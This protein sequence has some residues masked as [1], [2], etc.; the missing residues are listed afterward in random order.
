MFNQGLTIWNFA[1][2]ASS[3]PSSRGQKIETASLSG[4]MLPRRHGSQGFL[5]GR[6]GGAP[7]GVKSVVLLSEGRA[8]GRRFPLI[9]G[10]S[11]E[12]SRGYPGAASRPEKG[13]IGFG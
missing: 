10:K 13:W 9:G 8:F 1:P 7:A 6:I 11:G 3:N 5:N 4:E 2:P 12:S